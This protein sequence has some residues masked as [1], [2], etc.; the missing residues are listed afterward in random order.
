MIGG[1]GAMCERDIQ[2]Q[3]AEYLT[4]LGGMVIRTNSGG[5]RLKNRNGSDRY[6]RFNNQQ[7][8]ADLIV[9]LRGRFVAV[10]VKRPGNRPTA[11][12]ELFA[13]RVHRAQ[14]VAVVASS[15][16]E[17]AEQLQQHGFDVI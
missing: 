3:I 16:E 7:G 1:K 2:K 8:C 9:C 6:V 15:V 12:Q 14:G 11:N 13:E 4:L 10:E 17:L 5:M